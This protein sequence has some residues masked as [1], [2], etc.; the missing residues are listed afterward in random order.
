M[1]E[2]HLKKTRYRPLCQCL[3]LLVLNR[4]G[5]TVSLPHEPVP[6]SKCFCELLTITCTKFWATLVSTKSAKVSFKHFILVKNDPKAVVII[7]KL[8]CVSLRY[9]ISNRS[10]SFSLLIA[11]RFSFWRTKYF[12]VLYQHELLN[13]FLST[14]LSTPQKL[15]QCPGPV[16]INKDT[17]IPECRAFSRSH[18]T[19]KTVPESHDY[20]WEF[21]L[22]KIQPVHCLDSIRCWHGQ[23]EFGG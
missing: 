13:L 15:P 11:A 6:R 16:L 5:H 22:A 14:M 17:L 8:T 3:S 7:A 1:H 9:E 19:H 18:F 23:L 20:P 12:S 4:P 21:S 10:P 2:N